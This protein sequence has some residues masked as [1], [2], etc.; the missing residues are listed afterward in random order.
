MNHF[1]RSCHAFGCLHIRTSIISANPQEIERETH[2]SIL[3]QVDT[4]YQ[5]AVK[6]FPTST[7]C[8][9]RAQ[10]GFVYHTSRETAFAALQQAETLEPSFAEL[11]TIYLFCK[12]C[13]VCVCVC[14]CVC[15]F[16]CV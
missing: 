9:L 3:E 8:L 6:R 16:V 1:H 12:V 7:M 4:L 11:F 5:H 15:A 13:S 14:V 10:Y 2:E